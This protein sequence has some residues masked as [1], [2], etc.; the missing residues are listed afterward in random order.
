MFS[1]FKLRIKVFFVFKLKKELSKTEFE[2][3]AI[4]L[5]EWQKGKPFEQFCREA[6]KIFGVARK[7]LIIGNF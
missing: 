2:S 5:A 6:L 7:N 3:F 1:F 4:A